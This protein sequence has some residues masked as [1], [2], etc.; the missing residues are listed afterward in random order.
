MQVKI[1]GVMRPEDARFAAKKGAKYI[2]ILLSPVSKR[3][4]DLETALSIVKAARQEGSEPVGVF[5]HETLDE[6][7]AF[8][9]LLSLKIVQLH[10]EGARGTSSFLS[11]DLV[12][13][14]VSDGAPYPETLQSERDFLLF[15]RRF[16]DPKG[17]RF[18]V[19]GG[20]TPDNVEEVIQT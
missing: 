12:Q 20:L 19:A 7:K 14:Y 18:F 5:V 8:V 1:C 9:E 2:G 4:V 10:G 15:E 3:K 11:P 17:F 16:D 13:I 6:I